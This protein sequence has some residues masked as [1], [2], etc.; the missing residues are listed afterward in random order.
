MELPLVWD[1]LE[2]TI[3]RVVLLAFAHA[4]KVRPLI[5][6]KEDSSKVGRMNLKNFMRLAP[7]FR[8]RY[9]LALLRRKDARMR[10]RRKIMRIRRFVS[11]ST[12]K[13]YFLIL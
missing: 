4:A 13:Y 7:N 9:S 2:L 12:D 5:L 1:V 6:E 3:R 10:L 8:L 11:K